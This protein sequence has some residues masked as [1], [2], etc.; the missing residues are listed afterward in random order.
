MTWEALEQLL[1]ST[2]YP[3]FRQGSLAEDEPYPET[4]WTFWNISTDED[5]FY[6]DEPH[7]TVWTWQIYLYTRDPSIMYS[8]M[9]DLVE[10]AREAGFIPVSRATDLASDLPE[11]VGRTI[12]IQ[13]IQ[14][15]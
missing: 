8:E 2:G 15:I 1:E 7:A 14:T 9:E 6:D 3:Y 11:W 12:R 13:Y 5:R 10:A 4:F